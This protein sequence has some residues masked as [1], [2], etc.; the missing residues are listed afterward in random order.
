MLQKGA[1]ERVHNPSSPG[2]YSR[3]FTIPK[4][5]G[6]FRP[7]LDLSPLNEF[8]EKVKFQMDSPD[9]IR[10]AIQP[11]DWAASLDLKDAYFHVKIHER[12][13]KWLRFTWNNCIFQ[14]RVLP[15]G[16]SLSPWVFT[17][18]IKEIVSFTRNQ[19]DMRMHAYLDD[20]LILASSEEECSR[21]ISILHSLTTR[22]GFQIHREKSELTPSQSFTYLGMSFN[23]VLWTIQPSEPRRDSL[24]S[25]LQSLSQR[26]STS[27]RNLSSLIGKME[28]MGRLL[29]LGRLFKRPLQRALS[30]RFNQASDSWNKLIQ[31]QPWF[32][33]VVQQWWNLQWLNNPIPI[34]PPDPVRTIFTDASKEGWGGHMENLTA[35]GKWSQSERLLHINRLELEAV[36]LVLERFSENLPE[37]HILIRSDNTTVVAL[38]NNQGGTHAPILSQRVEE[39]LLWALQKNLLLSA[40]HVAGSNNIMADLLSRRDKVIPT[41]W[42]LN[43]KILH[44]LWERWEKPHIDL[45]AT[46][47]NKR[48]PIYISPVQDPDAY[49]VDAMDTPW[50]NMSAYAFPPFGMIQ[51][52][53][54]KA[55]KENPHLILVTPWWETKPWFPVLKKTSHEPPV[56][57]NVSNEDLVQP[58]SKIPHG[59]ARTLNLHAWR[60][61]GNTC[62]ETDCQ[63]TL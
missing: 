4:S 3:L 19:E 41:E 28:S 46:K 10:R 45:F 14:F 21:H 56:P 26:S 54:E 8:L 7:I 25:S 11:G 57:L 36:A 52:V 9:A 58:R 6:G 49:G 17:K 13:R 40:K 16:L 30:S 59:N 20:W 37:G 62:V 51:A 32:P 29:A 38:I 63:K 23:S 43:Q 35:S 24:L 55:R 48:L 5:T 18:V 60:L 15:F 47:F 27:A 50:T 31:I 2:F 34:T 1:I 12:D 22:L 61:C 39:I 33:S 42:M 44:R 53:L